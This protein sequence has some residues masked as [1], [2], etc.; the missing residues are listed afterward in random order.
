MDGLMM[1]YFVLKPAK[2]AF[3][4]SYSK[5]KTKNQFTK[6]QMD[7]HADQVLQKYFKDNVQRIEKWFNVI[8]P[9]KGIM[10]T[11]EEELSQLRKKDWRKVH[12]I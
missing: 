1:K 7:Y 5:K 9:P 4:A 3:L 8:Q 12:S 6:V 2:E 10:K 11:L